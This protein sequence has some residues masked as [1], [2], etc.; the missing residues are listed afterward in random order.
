MGGTLSTAHLRYIFKCPLTTL[1]QHLSTVP[2]TFIRLVQTITEQQN[3]E[4]I[5]VSLFTQDFLRPMDYF[6]Q[7]S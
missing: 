3:E 4:E 7:S 6:D 2:K 5:P 1:E